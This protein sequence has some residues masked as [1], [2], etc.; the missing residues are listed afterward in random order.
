MRTRTLVLLS[1]VVTAVVVGVAVVRGAP[2]RHDVRRV[3]P[4]AGAAP[5]ARRA[6]EVL[7]RWDG[8]RAAA[9]ARDDAAGLRALYLPGSRAGRRDLAALAAYRR[10]GLRV[11]SMS[12]QVLAVRVAVRT[13]RTLRLVVTDR[14]VDGVVDG[15]VAGLVDG[16]GERW[17]LPSGR[18]TTRTVV[19]RRVGEE[20][21]VAEVYADRAS[22]AASTADTSRSRNS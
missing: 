10:R 13:P 6:V 20:W 14:L 2:P 15:G 5:V 21:R 22:P 18:P 3:I 4:A 16:V 8:Q 9:W 7:A 17:A 1:L 11:R 19:L 12:R